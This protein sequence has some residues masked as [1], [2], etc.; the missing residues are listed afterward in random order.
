[1]FEYKH[2]DIDGKTIDLPVG[3]VVC[4]GRNYLQHIKEL[5]N[6]VPSEPLLFIK[7]STALSALNR[8]VLIPKNL[9]PCHNELE[10]AVL[11]NSRLC[12]SSIKDAEAAIWGIGLG[13]DLTLRDVQSALKKQGH[14]WERAKAFDHSC[15]MSQF[16]VK[17]KM[18]PLSSIDF[19]LNVND[20]IR[21]QGNSQEM[22]F[23]ILKLLV[24]ISNTF[25]LLPGDI[26]M[27]G[28]PTGVAALSVDDQLTIELNGHF[29]I[30][31]IVV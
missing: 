8:P 2:I 3:K 21:Q 22:L 17:D 19:S 23:P 10:V 28:T 18:G 4:V 7:P 12:H 5:D 26:V 16:V 31:T 20:E 14:P 6:D 30:R 24:N 29:S 11:I 13:L 15:P 9:G 27:T 25:T 1:M